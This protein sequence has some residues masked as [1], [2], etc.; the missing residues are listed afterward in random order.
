MLREAGIEV[1]EGVLADECRALNPRFMTAFT[2]GRPYVTL[3]W[4]Q[5]RD[6]FMDVARTG[7]EGAY[8]F[9]TPAGRALVHKL[10]ATHDAIMVGSGTERA[11]RPSLTVRHWA[12]ESPRRIVASGTS[13]LGSLLAK[14]RGEGVT[15]LLVE[16]DRRC[17]TASSTPA[18]GMRRAWRWPR[19]SSA[20]ADVPPPR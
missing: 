19:W 9:S 17:C 5:S 8:R 20:P 14:L 18:S 4:A 3:K 10:R 12:G 2:S 13:D 1:T 11:D 6:G 7:D 16:G 15:S